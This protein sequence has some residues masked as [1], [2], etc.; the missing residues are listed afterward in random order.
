MKRLYDNGEQ[1]ILLSPMFE[2]SDFQSNEQGMIDLALSFLSD[3]MVHDLRLGG[4]KDHALWTFRINVLSK[5][6]L[7]SLGNIF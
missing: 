7:L 3:A 1:L 4:T 5:I 6:L 2:D